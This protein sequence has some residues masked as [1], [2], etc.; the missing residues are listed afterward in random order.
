V[1]AIISADKST[2]NAHALRA[3]DESDTRNFARVSIREIGIFQQIDNRNEVTSWKETFCC[4]GIVD[5][6]MRVS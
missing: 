2:V 6:I 5:F 4:G 1:P 3:S